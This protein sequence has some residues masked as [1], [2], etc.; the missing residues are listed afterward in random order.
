[1]IKLEK[2]TLQVEGMTCA[3]CEKAVINALMDLGAK[4]VKASAR[5][6]TVDVVYALDAITLDEI[7]AEIKELGYY[8]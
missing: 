1:M 8:V 3:H 4:T 7:K 2:A 5:K 6:N